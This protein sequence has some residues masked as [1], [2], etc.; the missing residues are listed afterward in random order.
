MT[1]P[2]PPIVAVSIP[3]RNYTRGH[4]H[5][6]RVILREALVVHTTAGG[7]V[8]EDL[9]GWFRNPDQ[10][11]G[12]NT[13]VQV[14][15]H[16]GI[17]P[18]RA[19]GWEIH[20]YVP[21]ADTAHAHGVVNLPAAQIVLNNQ[22]INPN[23]WAI[24]CELVDGGK[25]GN[26][27]WQQYALLAWLFGWLCETELLPHKDQT[28]FAVSGS[29]IIAHGQIDSV[30]R[31][32]CP[33]LHPDRWSWLNAEI[34]DLLAG[35]A[36]W[37]LAAA[38]VV[39]PRVQI[40]REGLTADIAGWNATMDDILALP[41]KPVSLINREISDAVGRAGLRRDGARRVLEQIR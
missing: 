33:S 15:T 36:P 9:D 40:A 16:F 20:Q 2:K 12:T 3:E 27:T 5:D 4:S 38:P 26:H 34:R 29:R 13:P 25:P 17:G 41:G 30:T 18:T 23:L 32:S 7:K 6:G 35:K 1:V 10:R 19:G 22:G 37:G 14:S 11:D 28:G 31:A 39:D 21:L 8:I 24:G